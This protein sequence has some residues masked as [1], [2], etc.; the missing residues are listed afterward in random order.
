VQRSKESLRKRQEM[1]RAVLETADRTGDFTR[2]WDRTPGVWT[3]Y[4]SE[5]EILGDLNQEWHEALAG[6]IYGAMKNGDGDVRD[7]IALAYEQ[8]TSRHLR[9]RLLLDGHSD[10]PAIAAT[11]RK[12]RAV[13]ESVGLTDSW[14]AVEGRAVRL[15]VAAAS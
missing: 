10:H 12:E 8:V 4:A 7:D 2:P 15:M 3:Y 13:L 11:L 5:T 6:A 9:L 14:P 1:V